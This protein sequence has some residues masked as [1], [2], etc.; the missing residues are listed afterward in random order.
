MIESLQMGSHGF[1][2]WTSYAVF[3]AVVLW[4]AVAPVL[5]R[6]RI[7]AEI[8]EERLAREEERA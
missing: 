4:Q 2:I 7:I 8:R 3:A 5:R 6:R 1:Y